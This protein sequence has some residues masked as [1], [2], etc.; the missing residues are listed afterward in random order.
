MGHVA[1]VLDLVFFSLDLGFFPFSFQFKGTH[2]DSL[3]HR[4]SL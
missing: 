3:V 1:L 2:E 4:V